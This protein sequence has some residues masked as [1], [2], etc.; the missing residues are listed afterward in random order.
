MSTISV[1]ALLAFLTLT[2][3][4][5]LGE[6]GVNLRCRC[7]SKEKKPIGRYIAKLE[8]IP[9]NSHCEETEI[10]ATLKGNGLTI[11]LDPNV[12]WVKKVLEKRKAG[13]KP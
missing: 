11:C 9:T 13:K 4:M 10:I 1:V 8:V 3:G 7:I 12:S 5:G 2:V 6:Q